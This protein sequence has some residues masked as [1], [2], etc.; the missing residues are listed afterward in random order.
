MYDEPPPPGTFSY[1]EIPEGY[2]DVLFPKTA[3][4]QLQRLTAARDR[5]TDW[6]AGLGG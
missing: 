5:L 4:R 2:N 6:L 1:V 3:W